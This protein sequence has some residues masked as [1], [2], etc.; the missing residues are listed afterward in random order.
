LATGPNIF[1]WEFLPIGIGHKD[2][3]KFRDAFLNQ[4]DPLEAV[5]PINVDNG[6]AINSNVINRIELPS[7]EYELDS[8]IK[9]NY[10]SLSDDFKSD[11][12]ALYRFEKILPEQFIYDEKV[13]IYRR[14]FT[15]VNNVKPSISIMSSEYKNAFIYDGNHYVSPININNY[16]FHNELVLKD[17]QEFMFTILTKFK[18][19]GS[20]LR[21]DQRMIDWKLNNPISFNQMILFYGLIGSNEVVRSLLSYDYY[22]S[23]A[24]MLAYADQNPVQF[25]KDVLGLTNYLNIKIIPKDGFESAYIS[26]V[27]GKMSMPILQCRSIQPES[28]KNMF[29]SEQADYLTIEF[30]QVRDGE[31]IPETYTD[32]YGNVV[33]N[34]MEETRSSSPVISGY[35]P[36]G[37]IIGLEGY[38]TNSGDIISCGD[39]YWLHVA[40]KNNIVSEF[41]KIKSSFNE[42]NAKLLYDNFDNGSSDKQIEN[43]F[44]LIASQDLLSFDDLLDVYRKLK[45]NTVGVNTLGDSVGVENDNDGDPN[46][47]QSVYEKLVSTTQFTGIQFSRNN[48]EK[49]TV[50]PQSKKLEQILT[51]LT[52]KK[53]DVRDI[54]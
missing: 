9:S 1:V 21:E 40:I 24:D 49:F 6:I 23:Y 37:S 7:S 32:E 11:I 28:H 16:Q 22:N 33:K 52:G 14:V 31:F 53:I 25:V 27:D 20:S 2:A 44:G 4:I 47:N 51:N 15:I 41:D 45:I 8:Y 50:E 13:N 19:N 38:T 42:F 5:I 34:V 29:G 18:A 46:R 43:E 3:V 10:N 12:D 48:T 36:D 17:I 30:G 26:L 54:K 35:A 39:A